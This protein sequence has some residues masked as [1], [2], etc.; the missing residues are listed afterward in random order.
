MWVPCPTVL[1]D[2]VMLYEVEFDDLC[3]LL[4][5]CF[6]LSLVIDILV[7]LGLLIVSGLGL[8]FAKRGKPAGALLHALHDLAL[9]PLPGIMSP[10]GQTYSPWGDAA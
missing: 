4:A 5:L 1:D 10:R 8:R 2:P 9:I 7:A 6:V 3:V